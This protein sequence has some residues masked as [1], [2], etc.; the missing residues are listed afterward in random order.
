[1]SWEDRL[2]EAAYTSPSGIRI[3]FDYE[4]VSLEFDKKGTAFEFADANNTFV[5][6]TGNTSRRYPLRCF[7]WGENYDTDSDKF[8]KALEEEGVGKLEHPIYG[9]VDTVPFGRIRRRDDLKTSGNQAIFEITFWNTISIIYPSSQADAGSMVISSLEEY[10]A[11]TAENFVNVTDLSTESKKADFK[12]RYSVIL[13]KAKSGLDNVA[14]STADVKKEFNAI[15]DSINNSLDTLVNDPVTLA[16]QTMQLIQSPSRA[17]TSFSGKLD[18]YQNLINSVINGRSS[19][20]KNDYASQRLYADTYV[21][22]S[23]NSA[24]NN[25]F[26]TKT[27]ALQAAEFLLNQFEDVTNWS[28]EQLENLGEIDTGES[29]QKLQET[30]ALT[31]GFLVEI[32]FS[33]KQEKSI[34]LD[35]NRTIVD[36]SAEIYGSVDDQLDFLINSN[37]L[38]G[39]EILELPRGKE[40]LY[41]V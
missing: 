21:T 1:M 3:T 39:D 13:D 30:I 27:E 4:D 8:L 16:S 34:I 18:S 9:T 15:N 29:Y 14:N 35:R 22:G 20:N 40:I 24:I 25:E 41:Y 31:A 12:G 26:E 6:Q 7:F 37:N 5:Q 17:I 33:L 10:T 32:S 28:D 36:L 38:T 11:V 19:V 2:Q 23:I